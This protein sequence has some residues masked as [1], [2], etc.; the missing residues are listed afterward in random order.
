[1]LELTWLGGNQL[2]RQFKSDSLSSSV[3]RIKNESASLIRNQGRAILEPSL[4]SVEAN[5]A[6]QR[7]QLETKTTTLDCESHLERLIGMNF[8]LFRFELCY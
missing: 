2:E 1:M 5:P 7:L 3:G 8:T 4:S 6:S